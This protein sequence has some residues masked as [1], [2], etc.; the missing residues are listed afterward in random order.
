[1][2]GLL[3]LALASLAALLVLWQHSCR[4]SITNKLNLPLLD[5]FE[6]SPL[7]T[8]FLVWQ[9]LSPLSF[10]AAC[11]QISFNVT[12]FFPSVIYRSVSRGLG[13][14]PHDALSAETPGK[15]FPDWCRVSFIVVTHGR[16]SHSEIPPWWI[17][18][19]LE[20]M[21]LMLQPFAD[22]KG[23]MEP[24]QR[25]STIFIYRHTSM[26]NLWKCW[27][28]TTLWSYYR[29]SPP[30][31]T[32][33]LPQGRKGDQAPSLNLYI[34]QLFLPKDVY[35]AFCCTK[36]ENHKE[37]QPNQF[38]FW[39]LLNQKWNAIPLPTDEI[40]SEVNRAERML[41]KMCLYRFFNNF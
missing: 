39:F 19:R 27:H 3:F 22:Q 25:E 2:K 17:G 33:C 38:L 13:R 8:L 10:S 7:L 14:H 41:A 30:G 1:M 20:S 4:I 18:L 11:D 5:V 34:W 23:M 12:S 36:Q 37:I 28:R 31:V 21:L 35:I 40:P 24:L 29:D 6:L 26:W 16:D 9:H 15:C 32:W